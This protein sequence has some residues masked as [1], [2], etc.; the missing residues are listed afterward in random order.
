MRSSPFVPEY[1]VHHLADYDVIFTSN[2][3]EAINLAAESLSRE[4]E[5]GTEPVVLNTLLEHSSND[6]PWRMIPR[7]SL[8]RL[9][10]DDEGFV[11]LNELETLFVNT[12][13]RVSME[14]SESGLWQ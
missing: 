5:E 1:W 12:I 10:V 2:T 6:L 14:R 9:S 3:T 7:Y 8:I 13:R 4:S 11:D